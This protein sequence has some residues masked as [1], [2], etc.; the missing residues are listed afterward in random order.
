[1]TCSDLS[2][3]LRASRGRSWR[4]QMGSSGGGGGGGKL[5]LRVGGG[6]PFIHQCH[7]NNSLFTCP[8]AH[9]SRLFLESI[10]FLVHPS[11]L[12]NLCLFTY[13]YSGRLFHLVTN[14]LVSLCNKEV[15][16]S[17]VQPQSCSSTSAAWDRV[18][19]DNTNGMLPAAS[20]QYSMKFLK[21]L[22]SSFSTPHQ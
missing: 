12:P 22:F 19:Y 3:G 21:L 11:T 10:P 4:N 16:P 13:R 18:S 20:V 15:P 9:L 8:L 2:S 7:I 17:R 1:M 6:N 5:Q 14:P